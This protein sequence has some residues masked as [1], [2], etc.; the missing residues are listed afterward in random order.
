MLFLLI[1]S[2]RKEWAASPGG[3]W[4]NQQSFLV[5]GSLLF[6]GLPFSASFHFLQIVGELSHCSLT[7]PTSRM[8]LIVFF[9]ICCLSE[10]FTLLFF[11]LLSW[12]MLLLFFTA[13]SLN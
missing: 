4:Q 1:D 6:E 10:S 2:E 12:T 9:L 8:H 11:V 7:P 5:D 3:C 13:A